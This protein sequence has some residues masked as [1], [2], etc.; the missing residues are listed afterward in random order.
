M[1]WPLADKPRLAPGVPGGTTPVRLMDDDLA[2]SLAAGGRLETLLA[3]AEFATSPDAVDP[4]TVDPDTG[5]DRALCLAIDPDLVV[6]VNA[7]TAGYVVSD[8]PTVSAQRAIPVP[9]RPPPW[10]G[11]IGSAGWPTGCASL[12]PLCPGRPRRARPGRGRRPQCGGNRF[13]RRHRRQ[14]RRRRLNIG[15]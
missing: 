4:D 8:S 14:D 5:I 1:L 9:A 10:R 7:M 13:R 12:P 15:A 3:A 2:V 11:W 6:T